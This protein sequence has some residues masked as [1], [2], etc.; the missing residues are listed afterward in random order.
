[1]RVTIFGAAGLL[2]T[3][4]MQQWTSDEVTGL[5]IEDGD[6]RDP[7]QVLAMVERTRPEWIVLTAAYTDV[8][9]CET[10][11]K[12]AF[13][14]NCQ[15]PVNM[16]QAAKRFGARLLFI[17]TDYVFTGTNSAPYEVDAPRGPRS[18]YGESKA[19][20]E[21]QLLQILPECCIVRTSW[22]FGVRGK[23]FPD[24]VLK[25]AAT[26]PEIDVVDDQRGSPT[27][28]PDLAR[29][30]IQLC[31]S[32]AKGIVHVTNRGECT[33]FEFAREI[34]NAAGLNTTVRP[35][36]SDKFVRPAARPKYSVLSPKSLD[37]LGITMPTWQNA[38]HRYLAE[39]SAAV[40]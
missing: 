37:Q 7:Q 3:A 9:A 29:A 18:V 28:A 13:E 20:A 39:R 31:H 36:T 33:W 15:G 30:I 1:M 38:L 10:N 34:V 8:D 16:A 25:L 27:Y 35:T 17:S 5:D 26:R 40:L 22:L 4:L 21:I 23:S 14:V 24:T 19:E 6:I 11:R 12:L 2:G 32:G